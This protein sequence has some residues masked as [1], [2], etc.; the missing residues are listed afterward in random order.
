MNEQHHEMVLEMTHSSGMQGWYC[1]TCGRR[2]LLQVP[3]NSELVIVEP[4]DQSIGHSGSEGG[5]R[6]GAVQGS[7]QQEQPQEISEERLLPWI[8]A[9][10]DLNLDW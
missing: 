2:I 8:K 4:G 7:E 3:P 9:L 1:P 6:I 5:L 10:E